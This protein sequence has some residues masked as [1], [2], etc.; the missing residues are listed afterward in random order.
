MAKNHPNKAS[1]LLRRTI[2]RVERGW[3]QGA[4]NVQPDLNEAPNLCILGGLG[5]RSVVRDQA[6][7]LI[8]DVIMDKTGRPLTAPAH[9]IITFNDNPSTTKDDVLDV[10]KT[11]LIRAECDE[12]EARLVEKGL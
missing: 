5:E 10:L 1:K 11:A 8:A 4:L 2:K 3:V 6:A 12:A 7:D 9:V